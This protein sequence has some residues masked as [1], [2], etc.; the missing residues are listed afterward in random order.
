MVADL[1]YYDL[2]GITSDATPEE[3]KRAYRKLAN[4]YHPD[5]TNGDKD[6]ESLFIGIKQAYECLIDA[7][8]RAKYD[9]T[10]TG[11]Q[12]RV[13]MEAK[14]ILS[15]MFSQSIE[16]KITGKAEYRTKYSIDSITIT[17]AD[18]IELT[19]ENDVRIRQATEGWS[20]RI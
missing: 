19:R 12:T 15:T 8:T 11:G 9:E 16:N 14:G 18:I 5:K 13:Q 2:L 17:V 20:D 7:H 4:Q 3:I 6:K 1:K 10:G